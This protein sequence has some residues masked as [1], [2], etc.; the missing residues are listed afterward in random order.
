MLWHVLFG[1]LNPHQIVD[2]LN[3]QKYFGKKR[4]TFVDIVREP[5]IVI[6]EGQY[7]CRNGVHLR[8]IFEFMFREQRTIKEKL[9][10]I[11]HLWLDPD[12]KLVLV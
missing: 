9:S 11:N 3:T 8:F 5:D 12:F 1:T 2:E 6:R 7:G 4:Q 10:S